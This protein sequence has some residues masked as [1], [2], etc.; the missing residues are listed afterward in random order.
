MSYN[1]SNLAQIMN[2][3]PHLHAIDLENLA[4]GRITQ[5][6]M[7]V[8]MKTLLAHGVAMPAVTSPTARVIPEGCRELA[9]V[10]NDGL[11]GAAAFLKAE[12]EAEA[13]AE[14]EA[15]EAK[16]AERLAYCNQFV[17]GKKFRVIKAGGYISGMKPV[18]PYVQQ[19]YREQLEVG[20]VLMCAGESMTFGDG[21]PAIK[22][23]RE[24][25]KPICNDA[26]FSHV[27]GGM[28]AGQVP[29]PGWMELVTEE[30]S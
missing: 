23:L 3:L 29:E 20:T 25:G 30:A 11:S 2:M 13:R 8:A 5:H 22:W 27:V 17:R 4:A 26:I 18:A 19:G 28:W 12:E 14:K 10:L 7:F 21:V 6:T 16:R 24:D 15:E 9:D 1:K